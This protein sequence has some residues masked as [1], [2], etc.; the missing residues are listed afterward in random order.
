[1]A[2]AAQG[3]I[4]EAVTKGVYQTTSAV[5]NVYKFQLQGGSFVTD[6]GLLDD[7]AL[8]LTAILTIV[9]A[10]ATA[11]TTWSKFRARN[12]TKGA[13]YLD[14]DFDPIIAG[15]VASANAPPGACGLMTFRT[16]VP[17]VILKKYHGVLPTTLLSSTGYLSQGATGILEDCVDLLMAPIAM[18]VGT[19]VYGHVLPLTGQ[20]ITPTTGTVTNLV[21]YQRRRKPGVGI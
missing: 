6:Q 8:L 21:A 13:A 5:D 9:K 1:M 15:T 20:F 4:I 10:L 3:D 2:G 12:L 18:P 7:V 17:G 16:A 19:W 14:G 11:Q